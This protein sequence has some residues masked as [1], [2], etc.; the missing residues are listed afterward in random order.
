[1]STI[2]LDLEWNQPPPYPPRATAASPLRNEIIQIGA[3]KLDAL[4]RPVDE[5]RMS[6][7]P[8]YNRILHAHVAKLTG[9]RQADLNTGVPFSEAVRRFCDWCGEL[10]CT[11]LTWG[12]DDVSILRQNLLHYQLPDDWIQAWYN[13]QPIYNR[14][15]D[16]GKNQV[17]LQNAA[18]ALQVSLDLPAHDA[19]NDA[20]VTAMICTKLDFSMGLPAAAGP[21]ALD[22]NSKRTLRAR[23]SLLGFK[24]RKAVLQDTRLTTVVCPICHAQLATQPFV[25]QTRNK[26]IS[27]AE[28]PQHGAFFVRVKM[29]NLKDKGWSAHQLVYDCDEDAQALYALKAAP[30]ETE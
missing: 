27:L 24:T 20:R 8:V 23:L 2:V 11:I 22:E 29:S 14:Q 1:M 18:A 6:V 26:L 15:T 5:F 3:V 7:K 28:C 30:Q 10:P 13:L 4:Y 21:E 9:L 25:P 17:S 19:L 16:G 12:N